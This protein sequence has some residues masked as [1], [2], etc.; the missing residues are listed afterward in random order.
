MA[1]YKTTKTHVSLKMTEREAETL[2]DILSGSMEFGA[3]KLYNQVDLGLRNLQLKR[4]FAAV[5]VT[6]PRD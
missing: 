2:R 4:R 1:T 5:S 6:D 3:L